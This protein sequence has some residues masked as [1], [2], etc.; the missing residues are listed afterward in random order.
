LG[1]R[2][3]SYQAFLTI[4]FGA[5]FLAAGLGFGVSSPAPAAFF[6]TIGFLGS[7]P[8]FGLGVIFFGAGASSAAA[9]P[10]LG[11]SFFGGTF[12]FGF[13]SVPLAFGL[14]FGLVVAGLAF[15]GC[16]LP[17]GISLTSS[18]SSSSYLA[19]VFFLIALPGVLPATPGFLEIFLGLTPAASPFSSSLSFFLRGGAFAFGFGFR[20]VFFAGLLKT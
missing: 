7:S 12:V 9:P 8:A 17:S 4:F 1:L 6:F 3:Q 11:V 5:T 10:D 15:G 2:Q 13:V 14:T 20:P 18:S 16:D 19:G